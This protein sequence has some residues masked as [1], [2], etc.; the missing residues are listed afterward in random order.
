[1]GKLTPLF[2]WGT[3]DRQYAMHS[4]CISDGRS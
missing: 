4:V 3:A 1:L 2:G